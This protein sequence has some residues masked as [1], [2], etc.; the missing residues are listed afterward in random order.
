M[1]D[2]TCR[3]KARDKMLLEMSAAIRTLLHERQHLTVECQIAEEKL[4][5]AEHEF[6]YQMSENCSKNITGVPQKI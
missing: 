5:G 4:E 1:G 2:N 6:D 3:E